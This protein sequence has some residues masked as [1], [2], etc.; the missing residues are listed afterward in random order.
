LAACTS[1][2]PSTPPST[3]RSP[4][5]T[6]TTGLAAAYTQYEAT[7]N[8]I[9]DASPKLALISTDAAKGETAGAQA[10]A[11]AYRTALFG[12]DAALRKITFPGA[13]AAPANA[14]LAANQ[15]EI[16]D[17]DDYPNT[18]PAQVDDADVRIQGDDNAGVV[19]VDQLKAALGHPVS[20]A[21]Y[22][23]DRFLSDSDHWAIV[24]S[25]AG[26]VFTQ[27]DAAGDLAGMLV[28]TQKQSASTVSYLTEIAGLNIPDGAEAD[29]AKFST[30]GT[31]LSTLCTKRLGATSVAGMDALGP[32]ASLL[33]D[34]IA[35][36]NALQADMDKAAA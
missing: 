11:A 16:A 9:D 3:S 21:V 4:A 17:L 5:S 33:D 35:A 22:A 15:T 6:P 10:A 8:I 13:A 28:A 12:W 23:D 26:L 31:A 19:A 14:V 29:L 25:P 1:R 32:S 24:Y 7:V 2:G 36:R 18:D 30:T 27:D 20:P 34:F